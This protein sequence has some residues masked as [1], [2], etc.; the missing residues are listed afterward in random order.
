MH[1]GKAPDV[2]T[3]ARVRRDGFGRRRAFR[4]FVVERDGTIVGYATVAPGYNSDI[5]ERTLFVIDLYVA[6]GARRRGAGRALLA[7]VA[8]DARRRGLRMIEWGV[9]QANRRARAFYRGLGARDAK[10]RLMEL[11]G[12]ALSRL[13]TETS[14]S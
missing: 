12:G 6:A 8:A 10:A 11:D 13:A 2:F 3:P 14:R 1:E 5:A 9:R 7:A 4:A